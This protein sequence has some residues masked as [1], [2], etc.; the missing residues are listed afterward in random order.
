MEKNVA[1]FIGQ[2]C[3][4]NAP[5]GWTQHINADKTADFLRDTVA[6]PNGVRYV[7]AIVSDVITESGKISVVRTDAGEEFT[8]DLFLDATGFKR[9]LTS[10]LGWKEVPYKN[11]VADS[12]WV[13]QLDYDDPE[14]EMVNYTQSI[15][16]ESGWMFKIGVY[17]R[18]GCGLVYGSKFLNDA[19][20][21][22]QYHEYT[23]N[24]RRDPRLIKWNPCRLEK[25]GDSNLVALGLSGG[26]VE[27][28]EANALFVII[29]SIRRLYDVIS[30]YQETGHYDFKKFNE[31]ITYSIDDISDFILVHYTLSS[32]TDSDLWNEMREIGRKDNHI[33][34]VYEKYKHANNTMQAALDGYTMFPQYMWAQWAVH[35][36]IDTHKWHN[37]IKGDTYDLAKLYFLDTEKRHSIISKSAQNNHTWL[38]ENVFNNLTPTEWEHR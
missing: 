34:L 2:E 38:K 29:N 36:G 12:A 37:V 13:C 24:R 27:P 3:I 10:A 17:H 8:A 25:I 28:L 33:D 19:K 22:D 14:I 21:L 32:R 16:K 35:M 5:F 31:I 26:F 18:M 11:A 23:K 6:I 9:L 7:D 4:L 20:A 1:P 15:A 30:K